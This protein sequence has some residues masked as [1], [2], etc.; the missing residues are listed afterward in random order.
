M[1][2]GGGNMVAIPKRLQ[3][4]AA[5]AAVIF[6]ALLPANATAQAWPSKPIR[7]VLPFP[8]GGGGID[9]MARLIGQKF[10]ETF[11]QP[12]VVENRSGASGAIAAEFV[13]KAPA[14]G[15][16]FF[17]TTPGIIV[18]SLFMS[19]SLPYDAMKDFTPVTAAV[20]PVTCMVV[21]AGLPVNN[22]RELIAYSKSNPDKV[23]YASNGVG[24]FF[25]LVGELFN[26]Q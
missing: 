11:G 24:S 1:P 18:T 10:T 12:V 3:V 15:Y 16:T 17:F 25:H 19:K 20:E 2:S 8:P 22:V 7:V 14:D 5:M 23:F 4:T 21:A 26:Q 9:V 6:S 13:A